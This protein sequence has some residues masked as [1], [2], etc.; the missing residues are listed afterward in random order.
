MISLIFATNNQHKIT[1]MQAAIGNHIKILTLADAGI[2]IDIEEPYTTLEENARIK[3]ATI[4]QMTGMN[5]F[6]EDSGLEVVAL[7]GAPGVKS[8]RYAG[9]NR[10]P[11]DNINKLLSELKGSSDRFASFR[12]VISLLWNGKEY[13]F[14]GRCD[15]TI[16]HEPR[17]IDG[18]GYDP[19]FIPS[20]SKL[21][22]AEMTMEEKNVFSHRKKAADGLVLFLQQ[23]LNPSGF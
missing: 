12:T 1:E 16:T 15:G 9:E 4:H 11:A 23:T 13:Q 3:T 22:F 10:K 7:G 5:C 19:V 20:G 18:F 2:T 6:G 8:A 17:G 21:T 14:Q